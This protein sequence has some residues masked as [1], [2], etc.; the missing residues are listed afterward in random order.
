M[1][2]ALVNGNSQRS[3]LR[4]FDIARGTISR[5]GLIFGE[6]SRSLHNRLVRGLACSRIQVDEIWSFIGKK[7][8]R[9]KLTDLPT[10]GEAYTFTAMDEGSRLLISYLVGK[11]DAESTQRFTN[12]Y[13][14]RLVVM[15]AITSD[16]FAPYIDAIGGNFGVTVDYGQT[17]KNYRS[18]GA[19]NGGDDRR[20]E[21]PRDP[22]ITKR[23]IYG[24]PDLDR[25][26]TAYIERFNATMRHF[27]GRMRRLCYAF[28]K[29]FDHHCAAWSLGVAHYN[30]C[31]IIPVL[32]VT[33]AMQAGITDHLWGLE[34]FHDTIMS[35]PPCE[36]PG[37]QPLAYRTPETTSRELP[38]GRGFLRVVRDTGRRGAPM[39]AAPPVVPAEV[40]LGLFD[41]PKE[42]S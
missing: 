37:L 9:V 42:P 16:G 39:P 26:S 31:H 28:S 22:F 40:Q 8:K 41:P 32:R 1:L 15:P 29:S 6:G 38:G 18:R 27:I 13:R 11:R 35:E 20:Y 25:S 24:A 4:M 21:P 3:I 30:L 19:R 5:Y 10:V 33:P 14:K 17:I 34:E 2:A 12:D 36:A 23:V 7:E